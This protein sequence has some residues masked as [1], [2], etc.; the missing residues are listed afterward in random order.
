MINRFKRADQLQVGDEVIIDHTNSETVGYP[1]KSVEVSH[2]FV[3][4]FVHAEKRG[5]GSYLFYHKS[6]VWYQPSLENDTQPQLRV[7]TYTRRN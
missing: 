2:T 7:Q 5:T 3:K 6:K 4:V 1:I